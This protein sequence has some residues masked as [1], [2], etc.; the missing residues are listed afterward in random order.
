MEGHNLPIS[1]IMNLAN[2]YRWLSY[3]L[4][5]IDHPRTVSL[6]TKRS[7][8][9]MNGNITTSS[10]LHCEIIVCHNIKMQLTDC[11]SDIL[12]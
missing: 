8:F 3:D 4:L 11:N 9:L 1:A 2:M 7:H 5:P 6:A 12:S 10:K